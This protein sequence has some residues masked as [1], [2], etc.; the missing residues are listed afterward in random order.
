MDDKEKDLVI[1]YP[2]IHNSVQIFAAIIGKSRDQMECSMTPSEYIK[3]MLMCTQ[4]RI[5]YLLKPGRNINVR[6]LYYNCGSHCFKV[7]PSIVLFQRFVPGNLYNMTLTIQ[8]LTKMSRSLKLSRDPDPFFSVEYHG[9]NYSTMIAPGLVQIYNV[10][11]SPSE[12][13]DYEYR[14]KFI[15]DIEVFMI[16][17]IAIGLRPILDIPDQIEIPATAVKIP[18]SK[19]ILV[20]NIGDAPATFNFCSES[21]CFS[22]EPAKGILEE[23]KMMQLTANFLSKK[24]GDFEANVL[25]N[26]ESGEKLC[27]MLRSSAINCTIRIDR[28]SIRM[29]DTYLG[30]SRSKVLTIH[31]RSDYIVK[32]QWMRFK[33]NETDV[34]RK[35]EYKNLFQLVHRVEIVRRVNLVHYNICL[36]DIHELVCQ[37]IYTDEIASLTNEDFR[38]NHTSFLLMPEEGE[39]WPQSSAD[40]TVIFQAMEVGEISSVA[41]LEVMGREDRIP[42]SLH[43]TG[44]GPV[45]HLNVITIDLSSI[46]LCSVH[47][48]EIVAANHG[49]IYGTLIYKERPT[50]FGGTISITPNARTLKPD[51]YK[52]FNL[53]FSSNRK[54]DFIERIDFVIKESLEVLS[55]Y[56]KGCVICPT[57]HFDKHT[58]DFDE[59]ALGFIQTQEVSLY[60]LSV[61]PVTFSVT[62]MEDGDQ[63]PLTYEEFATSKVKPSFPTN[64]R[65]F[66]VIPQ[67]GVVQ[68]HSSLKLKVSY[69]ANVVRTGRTNM[70]VDMWDSDSNPIIL[71]LSFCGAIP[72][73]SIKPMEINIRFSFINFPY[74]RSINVEN[75]SDLDGYFY[76]VPQTISENMFIV[77]SLSSYQG[78]L[79]ARQSKTIDITII[80][81][82]LGRQTTTLN[83]LTMGEQAPVMSCVIIC[84]GRGPVVS[85]QPICLNFGEIQVL[86]DKIM[87]FNIINDSPIPAQFKLTSPK[88]KSSWVIEPTFG[89]VRPNDSEEIKVKLFLR[90]ID[91]YTDNIIV[92]VINSRSFSI[93]VIATGIGCSIVFEP[94]IFPIFDMGFLFSHQNLSL[95]VIIKNF[96]TRHCQIIWSN[97]PE[98]RIQKSQTW[99]KILKTLFCNRKFQIEP[100]TVEIPA[101]GFN[102]VQC[103]I[104]WNINEI[105]TEDWY[106]FEQISGQRKQKLIGTSTFKATFME[107]RIAFNKRELTF[108]IDICPEGEKLQQIDKLMVTNQSGMNLNVLL[109]ID[110]PFYLMNNKKKFVRE[111]KIVLID[112]TSTIIPVKFSPNIKPNYPYSQ[113]YSGVLWFEYE[114]HPTKNKIQC[115]GAVNFPNI[116]LHSKNLIINSI[117]GSTAKETLRV[118]NNGP[119]P[120]IYKFLW[121]GESIEIE[122]GAHDVRNSTNHLQLQI[123]AE[124]NKFNS[125]SSNIEKKSETI[126]QE[127]E[128]EIL[129]LSISTSYELQEASNSKNLL[130]Q[131]Q[132]ETLDETLEK[133]RSIFMST[134]E[135]SYLRCLDDPEILTHIDS[136]FE[137]LTKE[138]LDDILDIIPHEGVLMPFSSQYISFIFHAS[139]PMQLK[140]VALCEILQ[141]PTEI[142]NVF[143]SADVI[144]YSV[145]KQVIDFGQQLFGELCR[146]SFT[147]QNH[148][149]ICIDYKINK[150]NLIFKTSNLDSTIGM[151]TI[152]PN[153]G[154]IDPLSSLKITIE[155]QPMLL[156]AFEIEFELQV[157][158]V[159]P[160][161]ITTKGITSYPQIYPCILRDIFKPVKLE[162]R[163]IQLLTP[164]FITMKKQEI[165]I[166]CNVDDPKSQMPEWDKR[167]LLNNGWDLISYEEIFPSIIDIEMSIDRLLATQFIEENA[168]IL[169]KH[170]ISHK[171]AVIPFLYTSKY[172]ID[173]GYIAINV[174]TCYSTTV[175]NYGPWN[176]EVEIKKLK[177]KQLEN[178]GILVQFKK[179]ILT[180]GKTTC[181]TI[182]WQP[183]TI[184]YC[185]RSTREQHTIYLKVSHGSII[186]IIIKSI[187]TYPFVTVNTKL[188]NFQ[189]VIVGECLMMNVL[190]KNEG[191]INCYWKANILTGKKYKDCPF[192]I[193]YKSNLLLPGHSDIISVYFKP[194]KTCRME[195]NLKIIVKMGLE[196]QVI[197]LLG[198]GIEYKLQIS[199]LDISFPPTVIFTEVLEKTF[200]IENKCNYPVEFFWH[201]LDSLFLEEQIA[202]ALTRYYGVKEILLPPRKLGERMPSS[203]ME[204]Y[205][206]LKSEMAY[207]LSAEAIEKKS[208]TVLNDD[209]LLNVERKN[210]IRAR[211]KSSSTSR[212]FVQQFSNQQSSKINLQK[213]FNVDRR[214]RKKSIGYSSTS[215]DTAKRD[216]PPMSVLNELDFPREPPILSTNDPKELHNLLLYYI[217]TLR[218]DPNFCK[219]KDPV[220]ELF[221]RHETKSILELDSSQPA[222][223]VCILFHGAPFTEYQETACRSAKALQVSL[224]C[225][226]NVIIEGIALGDSWV[227]IKLRQII[228]EAYQE[229]LSSFERYKAIY[230][231]TKKTDVEIAKNNHET[232]A[233]KELLEEIKLSKTTKS[234]SETMT[235]IDE[236]LES[237]TQKLMILFEIEFAKLPREQDLKFLDP[238]SLY[239]YKI[240]TILLLQKMFLHYATIE[241]KVNEKDQNDT[242][243]GIEI[244]LLIEVLRERAILMS[245]KS[246]NSQVSNAQTAK[247]KKINEEAKNEII[248]SREEKS[249]TSKALTFTKEIREHKEL[250]NRYNSKPKRQEISK[251]LETIADAMNDY[252]SQLS[253][254]ENVIKNW[255]PLKKDALFTPKGKDLKTDKLIDTNNKNSDISKEI[256][257]NGF[258]TWYVN[259]TDPWNRVMY[260]VIVNQMRENDLAKKARAFHIVSLSNSII[261][262]SNSTHTNI[263]SKDINDPSTSTIFEKVLKPRWILQPNE[264]Q[265]FKIRY[266][267]EEVGIHR[268]TYTLS[269]LDGNEITYDINISAVADVPRLDMNPNTIFSK[270]KKT[271]VNNIIDP[272][273]FSDVNIF[274]FGSLLV[275]EKDQRFDLMYYMMSNNRKCKIC[276]GQCELLKVSAGVTELG[277]FTDKLYICIT[278]NPHVESIEL[279]CNGSK[280]DI[281]LE[282]KQ[283]SFGHIFLHRKNCLTSHIQNRSP[284]KIFWQ[285]EP[286]EPLDP[287]ISI[288][289]TKGIIKTYSDKTIEFCY[290]ANKIGMIEESLTF[291]VFFYEGDTEPIFIETITL[292]GETYDV[293]VDINYAN[294]IDLKCV[295]V[296]F[297]T[298][299]NFT[300]SNRG[301]HEVKYAILLE[302]QNK[303]AKIA[304]NL[305]LKLNEDVEINPASGF[306]QPKKEA[307][308]QVTFVPKS[309]ITLKECPILR[310]HLLEINK[311]ATVIAE[312]P[313]TVSLI[314]Y[315]TKFRIYPYEI[316]FSSLG[317]CT[318][319]TLYLNVENVGEFPLHYSIVTS[320]KYPSIAYMTEIKT[321]NVIKNNHDKSTDTSTRKDKSQIKKSDDNTTQK[322]ML[323]IGPFTVT[324][325]EGDLQPG[326]IDIVAI[327]CY[328]EFVGS[329]EEDIIIFVP[330][331]VPEDRNGK[332]IKLSVNSCIPSV[333]LQDLDA[334]FHE[335]HIVNHI[336]DFIC[337]KEIG[338]Y[339]IFARQEKCLYFRYVSV[340]HTHTAY[341]VLYNRNVIPADVKLTLLADS[342]TPKTM[343]PD[344]FVL[345]PER[346]RIQSMSHKRFAISFNPTFIETCYAI[347]D[348]AV[349]LPLHLKDEKFFIKLVGQA[350]VPEVTIIEPLSTKRERTVLNFGRTLVGESIEKKFAF[351]NIVLN[352]RCIV[353]H[354]IPEETISLKVKFTPREIGRYNS[355]VRLFI[356]DNPY[357]NLI[358]DL[359]SETY[360]ELIV[361]DG[362]ELT[363]TK[364]KSINERR[365]SNAKSRRSLK[366]NSST[367]VS[368]P[369]TLPVSLIYKLDYGYCFVNK[370]YRKSFK[371][372]NKSINQYLRF[373]WSTHPNVVF[374][375]SIG[376]LIPLTCKE[377]VATFLSS[378]PTIYMDTCLECIVCAIQLANSVKESSWDDRETQVRWITI[379]SDAKEPN[380]EIAKKTVEP[381]N[382]PEHEIV[383]GTTKCIQVLLN[384]IVA[385]SKYSC[386]V[387]EIN[388]KNT[389]MFQTSEHSF[390]FANT[391]IVDV[392][393]TW[394]I[395]MDEQYPVR[396]IANYSQATSRSRKDNVQFKATSLMSYKLPYQRHNSSFDKSVKSNRR[397]LLSSRDNFI[398]VKPTTRCGPSDLF[399]SSARLTERSSDSWLESDD[400][401]FEIYPE[402]GILPPGESVECVLRFSPMDIFDYKAYLVCKM[403]NLELPELI[404]PIV[405]KS[406]L[407]YCHFDIPESDYLSSNRRDM[408]LPGPIGYQ[409]DDNSLPEGTR[410]IEL[411]VIGISGSHIKKF[412]MINPTSDDY[413]FIWEDRTRHADDEI[414]KFHCALPEGIAE[415]GKQVDFAFTFF[416]ENI[417]TFESFWL[418]RVKKYNLEYLFLFVATVREP[419]ICCPR[420]H[421]KM[422][423]TV[424]GVNV[425][426]SISIIN[427]EEFQIPFQ[428]TRDSLYSEGRLQNLKI[429]PISGIL[430]AKGEQILWVEYQPTLVGE[431]QF[432]V[433][434]IIKGMMAPLTIFVTTATYDIIVSVTYVDQ[435]GQIVQLNPDK[436][437]II[438]CGKLLLKTPVTVVF[439]IINSSKMTLYYSWDLGITSEII[440]RNMYTIAMPQKQDHVLSKSRSICSLIVTA[441]QK[442]VIKNHPI[443]LKISR[444][445]TYRLILK[446]T[447][448]KPILEFSFNYYDFGPCYIR[449]VSATPYH[450]DLRITNSDDVSY[451]LE[452]K[453]EE[454]PHISVNLNAI[455]K[456]IV[457]RS[458]IVI[459]ITFRPLEQV[460]YRD[461]LHFIINSTIK[462]KITIIGEGIIYK[463]RLVN[464]RDKSVDLGSLSI[465]KT[466]SRKVPVINDGR[467]ALKLKFDLIK[468]LP[469]YDLF[470]ERIPNCPLINQENSKMDRIQAS[471]SETKRSNTLDETLQMEPNLS[472]VLEIEPAESIVLQPGKIVNVVVKYKPIRRMRPF[473][474]KVAF[475]TNSTIQPLFILRGSCIGA[476]FHLN[477]TYVPFGIVVQGCLSEA[478]IVLLN[479]GDIG[480]RFKWNTL[481]LPED[482]NIAP[483]TGYCSPGMN[484]NFVVSFQPTRHDSLIE[485]NATLEI[486]KYRDLGL[487]ITG[488]SC[489]LP[490]PIDTLFFSCR[491][492]EKIMRSLNVENDIATL[493][494]EITGE[495]FFIDEISYDPLKKF[496]TCTLTYAPL[497]MNSES[498]LH[499]GT[500]LLKLPDDKAPLVYCLRG[501]SLPPQV[502]QR[503]TRQFPAKTKYTELLPVYN[504]LSRQQQFECQ[505]EN[506]NGK[507]SAENVE[508]F[509]FVGSRKIDIP[510]NGQRDY[511]A[512][513]YSYK[514]S[515]Y[516]F[517]VTFTNEEGEYQ[518]YELQY[519]IT[520]PQE[521]ESIKLITVVRSPVCYALKLDNPLKKQYVIYTAKC[522][523]PCITIHDVPKLVAPLCSE[524]IKI[525]YHPLHSAEEITVAL[526]VN[527][528][529]L[530]L[531]PYEL[532]LRAIPAS[533]EKTTRV[534]AMLGSSVTFSLNV[535]NHAENTAIFTIK[536]DNECFTT[537]KD[538]E[539]LALKNR[540]FDITYEPCD[541]KNVSATLTAT[542]EIA[543]EFVFP[544]IGTYSLPKP[545]G[546]YT[547]AANAPA[548][549]PFK[550]IFQETKSFELI[551]DDPEV[552]ITSTS[553]DKIKQKQAISIVVQL[554][555][556]GKREMEDNYPV[557]GK[558][559]VYCTDPKISHI[560]WIYYLR[561]IREQ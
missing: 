319:K 477:K 77:Y 445:P 411:D 537:S 526:D 251:E 260:D 363:N 3:Q 435:N 389:L 149:T 315:Y 425:R 506:M 162:Y 204:F 462:K 272:T 129:D 53:S 464:P 528:E 304:P 220:K 452:C 1:Y 312:F 530:G 253:A 130:M 546:P 372:V 485:G 185:K 169:T 127:T 19:T 501:L 187:I 525:K 235:A 549:I 156:G 73:L 430:P 338:T 317:I 269:V 258:H 206:S 22:I 349:E 25:L 323:K 170:L 470:Q 50:D 44:K 93:N 8:N 178:S 80:T 412:R 123:N 545:Q 491:V 552:F 536:V 489:K 468:N 524:I 442:T 119:I 327:E 35:E 328:P 41:Y 520:R 270:I 60:N 332:L 342:F 311:Q 354:L 34:Q 109:Y 428:I 550:N 168:S 240:Q 150:R 515:K 557:T 256:Y 324:K 408:K 125:H 273:Y 97:D 460:H 176:A 115:K 455:S 268:Q 394:Q 38:Y 233:K 365:E 331:S 479:M 116:T 90:D 467:A 120:V 18:S 321:E 297:P 406:L 378:E 357:E 376:H 238:I 223:K 66:T 157:T 266:L 359:K 113:N 203:L 161:T 16:P 232:I 164:D 67:T 267:P 371:V 154:S 512:E 20:R 348:I 83:M 476:K 49:H 202:E 102:V 472:Q 388:F 163:A 212:L 396:S 397:Q 36:P 360:A 326:E 541:V 95:P 499:E 106:I 548:S 175:V 159:D 177:K 466:T 535:N 340:F 29:E 392:E 146:S 254:I 15:S 391:G 230:I 79:K 278:N 350:C 449:D 167:I 423:P 427:K 368:T 39:I 261:M 448:N 221:D 180:V 495:Y 498:N 289:P 295:K 249:Q 410:V 56:I 529:E 461:D 522:Q 413:H 17:V 505:I 47:N 158:H 231:H 527:C 140:V 318:K 453:F 2:I 493:K 393:Y 32:F 554:K 302:K 226:D 298:S 200:T 344:T 420:V 450:V 292:F 414:S 382:E 219:R 57:L 560:N 301:N 364:L 296:G 21:S 429:T 196:T 263:I 252:Y 151:L 63:T 369:T 209:K 210:R 194:R 91:K 192:Y 500:L 362:L 402:K 482:F 277:L 294:P 481:K 416:A 542:S 503:I 62:I 126:S 514:E 465:N 184:K 395:N 145:D 55:L 183:T 255:D 208:A 544:L 426:E 52:S 444:G 400:L 532:R 437:N 274:D 403:E 237:D 186:P 347:F 101:N 421:L 473:V 303:L 345:I 561:G 434:C 239:E 306:I 483:A 141:G 531:F 339:T 191:F 173:M 547:V 539:V 7:S 337:S 356:T 436:E 287:Q 12:K 494:S 155:L 556:N 540:S 504:W 358:I 182:T 112:K 380:A 205:N 24:S 213:D 72:S 490:D 271:K 284:I 139:E 480:A 492:R 243:L 99:P 122:R 216:C 166:R 511:R 88:K 383:P 398:E 6:S 193:N 281:E 124:N 399:S 407:P 262:E 316:N 502:L 121:A 10:R 335:N 507:E 84:N 199:D 134:I 179:T 104:C 188:L 153:K 81:K 136:N 246:F 218:K 217:E 172:I 441:L 78:F 147:L 107:P 459:P 165:Q 454:K 74:S 496:T 379:N 133:L 424:M 197:T 117:L 478:K 257:K 43:G 5:N 85:V 367:R 377:I 415:R 276:A 370:I 181:L 463:I 207:A 28:R 330:D 138:P 325:T 142:V 422:R 45:L 353:V 534:D 94:Q 521:I 390:I 486:E 23:E 160:L 215:T 513:F 228:D 4:E 58:L 174:K 275:Y 64:P 446:A 40:I 171:N 373:Q 355:Q 433:K 291:K 555:D 13:R 484:V 143:A 440:S 30:L 333:N 457:A 247:N 451:I 309:E 33:D 366:S 443:L 76:I 300:L 516:N 108:C 234:D 68:A 103:K 198:H 405:G 132:S 105:L 471:I 190:V 114:E 307:I 375:P 37:R 314:A 523:H 336:E 553:L 11:F 439:E 374:T 497:I 250:E 46:F 87:N 305:S 245:T 487:K 386:S 385:F 65:E 282:D 474:V 75:D 401:P 265:K 404:I 346:E 135:T 469:G 89:E 279:Q 211:K 110:P 248:S 384:A 488:A 128:N 224:L 137:P 538:I 286:N 293:A 264:I 222:K 310:C 447:A 533:P 508:M 519:D 322:C 290:H 381:V 86:Q 118:T 14:I 236:H 341:L 31:N 189:N 280:L 51:Q 431:F 59:T 26:Y 259:S 288:T 27:L 283:L 438:D 48:Y 299:A 54:G 42:L 100:S 144:R 558:L 227:S 352:D 96:G 559:L 351:K 551:L 458:S 329:E 82:N 9:S 71:P 69:I 308:I 61:V 225:I 475:Q 361:L 417:G 70:R 510:A 201:H 111:K 320:I 456:T 195:A 214:K 517:M 242:F 419:L 409:P 334:I 229:Y 432:C 387:K 98:V 244:D 92:H 152:E 148:S 241:S 343:R 285:L 131:I 543:G 509:T 313:L 418:F 518:F